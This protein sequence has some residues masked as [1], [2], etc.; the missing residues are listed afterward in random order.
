MIGD[1]FNPKPLDTIFGNEFRFMA[2]Y[3]QI[4]KFD[5][6]EESI[7]EPSFAINV[8]KDKKQ[9]VIF[10]SVI[11]P[12]TFALLRNSL[13]PEQSQDRSVMVLDEPSGTTLVQN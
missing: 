5:P 11:G 1:L 6:A 10:S 7:C 12:K 8:I 9:V 4:R 2:T 3:G 13:A